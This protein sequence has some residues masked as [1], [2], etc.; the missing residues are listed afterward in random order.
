METQERADIFGPEARRRMPSGTMTFILDAVDPTALDRGSGS[1]GDPSVPRSCKL[2][3]EMA[4]K[5]IQ[6]HEHHRVLQDKEDKRGSVV[7]AIAVLV[8]DNAAG[9]LA[10]DMRRLRYGE[11]TPVTMPGVGMIGGRTL[12]MHSLPFLGERIRTALVAKNYFIHGRASGALKRRRLYGRFETQIKT[13]AI[14]ARR[15]EVSAN[16]AAI[17]ARINADAAAKKDTLWHAMRDDAIKEQ[18]RLRK[19]HDEPVIAVVM[20]EPSYAAT[21]SV[22][23]NDLLPDGQR[24]LQR[25]IGH[26]A[27]V[28]TIALPASSPLSVQSVI[29][30]LPSVRPVGDAAA[31]D[32]FTAASGD[33]MMAATRT[34]VRQR[35]E[36]FK[37][38]LQGE[39]KMPDAIEEAGRTGLI[40]HEVF[41]AV[42]E[43]IQDA[44]QLNRDITK[45]LEEA[46]LDE[47][48]ETRVSNFD[49]TTGIVAAAVAGTNHTDIMDTVRRMI[50]V[51]KT[52][53]RIS[54]A[55]GDEPVWEEDPGEY[56]PWDPALKEK[57]QLEDVGLI[58]ASWQTRMDEKDIDKDAATITVER[59]R[60]G[61]QIALA[62]PTRKPAPAAAA[63]D[64]ATAMM[65]PDEV[66]A[67]KQH[68]ETIARMQKALD[69]KDKQLAELGERN[70]ELAKHTEAQAIKH[71]AE[72]REN[73]AALAKLEAESA[74]KSKALAVVTEQME[75]QAR[76]AQQQQEQI[77]RL[78]AMMQQVQMAQ[79][80][81]AGQG[82]QVA[83]ALSPEAAAGTPQ[84]GEKE[85]SVQPMTPVGGKRGAPPSPG[86]GMVD[87]PGSA[88][89]DDAAAH[90]TPKNVTELG[91]WICEA[92]DMREWQGRLSPA[93]FQ[94]V[95][96]EAANLLS[97]SQAQ[98]FSNPNEA[99]NSV[100]STLYSNARQSGNVELDLWAEG[101]QTG[102]QLDG[103]LSPSAM[104]GT[105]GAPPAAEEDADTAERTWRA[106]EREASHDADLR[107]G[108][109]IARGVSRWLRLP[110][111]GGRQQ[112]EAGEM[113]PM[114]LGALTARVRGGGT[115]ER[116]VEQRRSG[117]ASSAKGRTSGQLWKKIAGMIGQGRRDPPRGG[118]NQREASLT[119]EHEHTIQALP[120]RAQPPTS[121]HATALAHATADVP[122]L[123]GVPP[124]S[125][126]M[127]PRAS[128]ERDTA[129]NPGRTAELLRAACGWA[130]R[131]SGT[132]STLDSNGLSGGAP[133]AA[134]HDV[135]EDLDAH[136]NFETVRWPQ[137]LPRNDGSMA[138]VDVGS[139]PVGEPLNL[140]T[141][142]EYKWTQMPEDMTERQKEEATRVQEVRRNLK[143]I[144]PAEPRAF[145]DFG[146]AA[147]HCAVAELAQLI[148]GTLHQA[149][150]GKMITGYMLDELLPN[151]DTSILSTSL[152]R[153]I[154]DILKR[155]GIVSE[156]APSV[157]ARM[158]VIH[159]QATGKAAAGWTLKERSG[160]TPKERT[161]RRVVLW[162]E[163]TILEAAA[164]GLA[165]LGP[166]DEPRLRALL[167]SDPDTA[168]RVLREITA[169]GKDTE[170]RS[171]RY[172]V[173]SMRTIAAVRKLVV[174]KGRTSAE[175]F[176]VAIA[177]FVVKG[178]LFIPDMQYDGDGFR[179]AR[180]LTSIK[181][182]IG[183]QWN[184]MLIDITAGSRVW[185]GVHDSEDDIATLVQGRWV[186]ATSEVVTHIPIVGEHPRA[187]KFHAHV[188]ATAKFSGLPFVGEVNARDEST[189]CMDAEYAGEKAAANIHNGVERRYPHERVCGCVTGLPPGVP[190]TD[191]GGTGR[192]DTYAGRHVTLKNPRKGA[193]RTDLDGEIYHYA[194]IVSMARAIQ[195]S[196]TCR[197]HDPGK[198]RDK[199]LASIGAGSQTDEMLAIEFGMK[200]KYF[201][202]R[203]V[204]ETHETEK[205][206]EFL[207]LI[208]GGV[209]KVHEAEEIAKPMNIDA[210]VRELGVVTFGAPCFGHSTGAKDQAQ[211]RDGNGEPLTRWVAHAYLLLVNAARLVDYLC[212]AHAAAV[213]PEGETRADNEPA[214]VLTAEDLWRECELLL[215][216]EGEWRPRLLAPSTT[217]PAVKEQLATRLKTNA[218]EI[219]KHT[220]LIK[221]LL[222]FACDD[223]RRLEDAFDAA[224]DAEDEG[225]SAPQLTHSEARQG[226]RVVVEF[227]DGDY[228]GTITAVDGKRY[229]VEFDDG[230]ELDLPLRELRRAPTHDDERSWRRNGAEAAPKGTGEGA[231]T[232]GAKDSEITAEDASEVD[233][234]HH[235]ADSAPG[236][237]EDGA[238]SS[239]E[240]QAKAK[241]RPKPVPKIFAARRASS[242]SSSPPSEP[243]TMRPSGRRAG[244]DGRATAGVRTATELPHAADAVSAGAGGSEGDE[245]RHTITMEDSAPERTMVILLGH[246]PGMTTNKADEIDAD[247]VAG[248]AVTYVKSA[249]SAD[250]CEQ[251]N[252]RGYVRSNTLVPYDSQCSRAKAATAHIIRQAVDA[253]DADRFEIVPSVAMLT[254]MA[255]PGPWASG[256]AKASYGEVM[257]RFRPA[258]LTAW[259]TALGRELAP[260][261]RERVRIVV[262]LPHMAKGRARIDVIV[263]DT[264]RNEFDT[265]ELPINEAV[266]HSLYLGALHEL[267]W[268]GTGSSAWRALAGKHDIRTV[269]IANGR[270]L[271]EEERAERGERLMST[272]ADADGGRK[273]QAVTETELAAQQ[274]KRSRYADDSSSDDDG[275]ALGASAARPS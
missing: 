117:A 167:G 239:T 197:G 64:E 145:T 44:H 66:A 96:A 65:A 180:Q 256:A 38:L 63:A 215:G 121:G 132:H 149:T 140:R 260:W 37:A 77:D 128:A 29:K 178:K 227:E 98:P 198:L 142:P 237:T 191:C 224:T 166:D 192:G 218:T 120:T 155:R 101:L 202:K 39:M 100:R 190:N 217:L 26:G 94:A 205:L 53:G 97:R 32:V 269:L 130:S 116:S 92:A 139:M 56:S 232:T 248:H 188:K 52:Q 233:E 27:F 200:G 138:L 231:A 176:D 57:L 194:P 80:T 107:A 10:N 18:Q 95:A 250:E 30:S 110:P 42:D 21:R 83:Q 124:V 270:T 153:R 214:A 144:H 126:A 146:R 201:D 147:G 251:A 82:P 85:A 241:P 234:V 93:S 181:D 16:L 136:S 150:G 69:A 55:I 106:R 31:A 253:D 104:P 262:P 35:L 206:N 242:T 81:Q 115:A 125:E 236:A 54:H 13:A 207:D 212:A 243:G 195:S 84:G 50:P 141:R 235:A 275:A 3:E 46:N 17:Q 6:V 258:Q 5:D 74:E 163:R 9:Y 209:L 225:E 137:P 114:G 76:T 72:T 183:G 134:E 4:K 222:R 62:K 33:A 67:T 157:L 257:G 185:H 11:A 59:I 174:Q 175:G 244:S 1:K 8:S 266:N 131:R 203:T 172:I 229:H 148:V 169:A 111:R 127:S 14:E 240:R 112:R 162:R 274:P 70:R 15:T 265:S 228:R 87:S 113:K 25:I 189:L 252:A 48:V 60:K 2:E 170:A 151:N 68:N 223:A 230:D 41:Y 238:H 268:P 261:V 103:S 193:D 171:H 90:T 43:T 249:G 91:Q 199:I 133:T 45:I 271:E 187:S 143:L 184:R 259:T 263:S 160:G 118:R 119:E 73:K 161:W 89:E 22:L 123:G 255:Q 213:A 267:K 36:C 159:L 78:M 19:A 7:V 58:L 108:S 23:A 182:V 156:K 208:P 245:E 24:A 226:A 158:A 129:R 272:E 264:G 216:R 105:Y 221:E 177:R 219:N 173:R 165:T 71:A 220:A 186:D 51:L 28:P 47:E 109:S 135:P 247:L 12:I 61:R 211:R 210:W 122:K 164:L 88:M 246:A 86:A 154:R 179:F 75:Q 196:M 34:M 20:R 99:L 49:G 79:G 273:R 152:K 102:A 168:E 254:V 40:E 204:V